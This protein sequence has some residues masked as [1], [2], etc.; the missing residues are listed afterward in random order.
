[1]ELN[2]QEHRGGVTSRTHDTCLVQEPVEVTIE[3][4]LTSLSLMDA[5]QLLAGLSDAVARVEQSE[6]RLMGESGLGHVCMIGPTR[7][8]MSLPRSKLGEGGIIFLDCLAVAKAAA[9]ASPAMP[10]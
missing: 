2:K 6:K 4:R 9:N 3:G 5:R 10:S 7:S 8:G 1:M